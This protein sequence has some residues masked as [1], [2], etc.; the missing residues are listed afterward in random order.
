MSVIEKIQAMMERESP[1]DLLL[2]MAQNDGTIFLDNQRIGTMLQCS[3]LAGADTRTQDSLISLLNDTYPAD[4]MFQWVQMGVPDLREPLHQ[5]QTRRADQDNPASQVARDLGQR[6]VDFMAHSCE[7]PVLPLVNEARTL[8]VRLYLAITIPFKGLPYPTDQEVSE[9]KDMRERIRG[10]LQGARMA[11]VVISMPVYLA[12]MRRYFDMYGGWDYY[13]D[14]NKLLR[15]QIVPPRTRITPFRKWL[16]IAVPDRKKVFARMIAVN[17]FPKRTSLAVADMFAGDLDG[18]GTQ[19]GLPYVLTTTVY[20]PDQSALS[21]KFRAKHTLINNQAFGPM[22]KWVPILAAKKEGHDCLGASLDRRQQPVQTSTV[23]TLFG[24][25]TRELERRTSKI[26]AFYNSIQTQAYGEQYI[27]VPT[28]FNQLPLHPS[29]Q[30]INQTRR[31][32]T[33]A[34]EHAAQFLPI[35]GDWQGYGDGIVLHT[36]RMKLFFYDVFNKQLNPNFN[37]VLFAESGAG[38]SF[39]VQA[40]IRDYLSRGV[41]IYIIDKGQSHTK[42]V[43]INGGQVIRFHRH[44]NICLN[45]FTKVV[46]I[47]DDIGMLSAIIGKMASPRSQL[48][49][50]FESRIMQAIMSVWAD[51]GPDMTPNDVY[52]WLNKQHEDEH[53][54]E[55]ARRLFPFSERGPYG[56]WFNGVNNLDTNAPIVS[57]ELKDLE[58]NEMLQEVVLL[59]VMLTTQA[60]MFKGDDNVEKM[61]I[62]EECGDLLKNYYFSKFAAAINSKVRKHRGSMGLI[63][64]NLSQLYQ[65]AFGAEIAASAATKF[66]MQQQG[67]AIEQAKDQKWLD[68]PG[69]TFE[70]LKGVQTVKG[71]G[72]YSEVAVHAPGGF[73]IARLVESRFNQVLFET[74]G[75]EKTEILGA[76][77]RGED[78]ALAID[79][80]IARHDG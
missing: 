57:I 23:L 54:I 59:Q 53:A 80:F 9:F 12:V 21:S 49:D 3:L 68:L 22:L 73:G 77:E 66:I 13:Y 16:R 69:G 55:L 24:H 72:G 42:L 64:Q 46:E 60:N 10:S 36:R 47:E 43:T 62:A 41:R 78:V 63:M 44:S 11:S 71:R 26:V 74:E 31:F 8:D 25:S 79:D 52:I 67:E 76:V 38:K 56:N 19:I 18:I 75:L 14:E 50:H 1:S 17:R 30:S 29:E 40:M 35:L 51:M 34:A 39:L 65:S 28:F 5:Y 7:Q 70:L 6:R 32:H 45:P 37:W 2:P 4:I 15:D 20:I 58:D 27:N 33:M 48:P 61:M